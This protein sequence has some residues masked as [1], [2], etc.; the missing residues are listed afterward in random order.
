M[1]LD[2]MNEIPKAKL[3]LDSRPIRFAFIQITSIA[4]NLF[5]ILFFLWL[6]PKII[7]GTY[8]PGMK[9]FIEKIYNPEFGIT[10][11]F[12]ANVIGSAAAFLLLSS[13]WRTYKFLINK[14]LW[15]RMMRYSLPMVVVGF[16]FVINELFDRIFLTRLLPGTIEENQAQLGIYNANYKL[17][18]LM[19]LFTQAFRYGAEP[20]FFKQK[21]KENGYKSYADVAKYF[22]IIGITAFLIVTLFIDVFKHFLRNPEYWEGLHVVPILLLANLFLGMY[23]NFSV[24]FKITDRTKYG[25]FI[26]LGGAAIT[27]ILNLC[28]DSDFWLYRFGMGYPYLLFF[29][30]GCLCFGWSPISEDSL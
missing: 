3:R 10:Y 21:E 29:D 20:F 23:Y 12:I 25:A 13:E 16:S 22:F 8:L 24:W 9:G 14:A 28:L 17:A 2:T 27:I 6:A 18:V 30:V 19:A 1:V 11:I 15:Q 5:F 4:L 7:A 26:S